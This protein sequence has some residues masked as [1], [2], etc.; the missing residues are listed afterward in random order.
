MTK[1]NKKL[2]STV[3]EI[4][5]YLLV[6]FIIILV[7]SSCSFKDKIHKKSL[8]LMSFEEHKGNH[9]LEWLKSLKQIKTTKSSIYL[10]NINTTI[11]V[12]KKLYKDKKLSQHGILLAS[13]LYFRYRILGNFE[14]AVQSLSLITQISKNTN[15]NNYLLAQITILSGFHQFDKAMEL[16]NMKGISKYKNSSLNSLL[17]EIK[18]SLGDYKPYKEILNNSQLLTTT[19]AKYALL[20]NQFEKANKLYKQELLNYNDTDPYKFSWLQ[21]QLGISYL[22]YGKLLEAKQIF[23]NAHTRFPEFYLVT[24]HL[25]ETELL[26]GNLESAQELY[27]Q[28]SSQTNNP[29]F[30]AQLA[31]VEVMLGNKITSTQVLRRAQV[32]F[33]RLV[34]YYPLAIGDHAIDFYLDNNQFNKA[35]ELAKDNFANRK[36]IESHLLLIKTASILGNHVLACQTYHEALSLSVSPIELTQLDG[37]SMCVNNPIISH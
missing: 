7:L 2:I 1:L 9:E 31:K 26:L 27:N 33:D 37:A 21:L 28:V 30:F 5:I 32:G 20:H 6:V 16:L 25:A 22:R 15:T 29:E 24:E 35:I 13:K 4:I 10:D 3:V 14:D 12:L 19:K 34:K 11:T 36:N 18:Y 23:Q 8:N 17:D